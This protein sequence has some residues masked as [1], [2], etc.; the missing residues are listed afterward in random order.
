VWVKG[1]TK[2][3]INVE[4]D[5]KNSFLKL[6]VKDDFCKVCHGEKQSEDLFN[7]YHDQ[8]FRDELN[9]KDN[10]AEVMKNILM[11]QMNLEK[12]KEEKK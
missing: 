9:K 3:E 8:K 1:M 5:T 11:I 2:P 7:K 10:E 4:G 6:S 12:Y